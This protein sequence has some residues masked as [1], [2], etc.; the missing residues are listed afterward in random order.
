MQDT[1]DIY[2]GAI[3]GDVIMLNAHETYREVAKLKEEAKNARTGVVNEPQPDERIA[4]LIE[5]RQEESNLEKAALLEFIERDNAK[6]R[7]HQL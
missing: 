6:Q 7:Q 1:L 2:T 3:H 4:V 5:N